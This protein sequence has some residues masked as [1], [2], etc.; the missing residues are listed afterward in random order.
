M[1][2]LYAILLTSKD[3]PNTVFYVNSA[4]EELFGY[5]EKEIY[6]MRWG[7]YFVDNNDSHL[8]DFLED[9]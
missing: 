8:S 7:R 3:Y 1:N 9:L 2:N 5:S 4:A 6:K